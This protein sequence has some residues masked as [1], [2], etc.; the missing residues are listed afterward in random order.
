MLLEMLDNAADF[1]VM[2]LQTFC[3]IC[4]CDDAADR[5]EGPAA[6]ICSWYNR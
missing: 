3:L 5:A 2:M 1:V 6:E 4:C